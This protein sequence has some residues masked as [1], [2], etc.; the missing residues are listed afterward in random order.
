MDDVMRRMKPL[1][2]VTDLGFI[3]YWSMSLLILL[4]V[5]IVPQAWL[6]KDYDDPIVYAWNWSFFPLDMVLSEDAKELLAKEGYD[7]QLG[8]RPLRRAIQRLLE[9]PLSERVLHKE[10]PAGS[11]VLVDVDPDADENA[12]GEL[13]TFTAIETPDQP[14]VELA[15]QG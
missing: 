11:T 5:D 1:L 9:D 7:P 12:S 13:L 4:G 14:P 10:F 6:F 15:D 2:L 8:A 3:L